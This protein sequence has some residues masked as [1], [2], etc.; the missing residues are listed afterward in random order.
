ITVEHA[1]RVILGIDS[2]L[3]ES[4]TLFDVYTGSQIPEDKKSIAFS[5]RYRAS[6]KTLTDAEIE[7]LHSAITDRLR[8]T[9]RA[10][11]RN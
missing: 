5:I 9:F 10:E 2:N 3:I 11:L 1:K 7:S 4:I 6:D 8:D